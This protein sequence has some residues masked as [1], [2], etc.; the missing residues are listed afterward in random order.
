MAEGEPLPSY[1]AGSQVE[2]GLV[3][4]AGSKY[5]PYPS[6]RTAP[7]CRESVTFLS[8]AAFPSLNLSAYIPL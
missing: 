2:P 1:Y 8:N 5:S 4:Y 7:A 3:T 6:G